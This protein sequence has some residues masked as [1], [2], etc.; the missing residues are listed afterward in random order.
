MKTLYLDIETIP[1]QNP[2]M[3]GDIMSPI[4]VDYADRIATLKGEI[5]QIRPPANYKDPAKIAEWDANERPKKVK[6]LKDQIA[7]L[8]DECAAKGEEA[9]RKTSFDGALGQIVVIGYAI[10][11]EKPVTLYLENDF[12]EL[13][14]EA[15]LLRAFFQ[16]LGKLNAQQAVTMSWVGHNIID[17]DFRFLFQRSVIHG[18]KPPFIIPFDAKPWGDRVFDTMLAWAGARGRV[19]QDKL[20]RVLGIDAKGTELGDEIDGSRVWDFIKE[21]RIADVATY[22]GGDVERAREIHRRLTFAEAA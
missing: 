16:M 13:R 15:T 18:I 5:E 4:A 19:G 12:L 11:N 21:G 6:A 7:R 2:V 14:S 17:F 22:C 8:E 20:C 10:D 1:V 9:W 3:R